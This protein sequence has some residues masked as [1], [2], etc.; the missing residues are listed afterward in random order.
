MKNSKLS[1]LLIK[2]EEISTDVSQMQNGLSAVS[3]NDV[4]AR[5][6]KGGRL[7]TTNGTCG[8][9]SNVSCNNG[10]CAGSGNGTCSNYAC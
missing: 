5:N 6:L 2:L 8:G 10:H 9:G 4:L 1:A 7:A 3:L